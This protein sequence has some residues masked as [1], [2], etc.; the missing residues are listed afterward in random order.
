VY[1]SDVILKIGESKELIFLS[2]LVNIIVIVLIVTLLLR[3]SGEKYKDIGFN[4]QN[5]LKQLKIGFLFGV[6]IF[7]FDILV[8]NSVV[9]M[10]FPS[11]AGVDL[12]KLFNNIYF[13]PVWI[14]I[15]IFKG[16]FS[17]ELWR[18]FGLTRFEKCFGKSGLVFALIVSSV[19]FGFGHLYQGVGGIIEMFIMGLLYASVY[20]RKRS[21]FEAVFA[22]TTFDIISITLAYIIY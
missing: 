9:D 3:L 10:I 21:A 12:S 16:G 4:K 14:F 11:S 8:I 6:L 7:V 2:A 20:L 1:Y 19:V 22:H 13:Y 18:I 5:I 17:E 15:A